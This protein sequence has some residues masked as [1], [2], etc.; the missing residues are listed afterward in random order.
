MWKLKS[1]YNQEGDGGGLALS[2]TETC[3]KI[4]KIWCRNKQA[5]EQYREPKN[6]MYEN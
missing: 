6:H 1:H 2:D 4:V 5:L 3:N